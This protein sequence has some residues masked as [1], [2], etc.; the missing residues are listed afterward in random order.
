MI[1]YVDFDNTLCVTKGVDYYNSEPIMERIAVINELAKRHQ[2]VIYT[3]RGSSSKI[4]F[5]ELT[6][7]QLSDWGVS[8]HKLDIGN[9]PVYDI[10]IDDKAF[11]DEYF[12]SNYKVL[13]I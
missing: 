6:K 10:L 12:F 1:I 3:A 5:E 2:I 7:V 4:D 13:N 9:K 11:S 8:Y